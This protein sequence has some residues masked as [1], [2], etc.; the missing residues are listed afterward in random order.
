MVSHQLSGAAVPLMKHMRHAS[1]YADIPCYSHRNE[2]NREKR[3]KR[4]KNN[5]NECAEKKTEIFATTTHSHSCSSSTNLFASFIQRYMCW[6]VLLHVTNKH[7][8]A[9]DKRFAQKR[10]ASVEVH[11]LLLSCDLKAS[12][13]VM[14]GSYRTTKTNRNVWKYAGEK[15][16][17]SLSGAQGGDEWFLSILLCSWLSLAIAVFFHFCHLEENSKILNLNVVGN[18]RYMVTVFGNIFY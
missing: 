2:K 6:F 13:C 3:H 7:H 5:E 1:W 15:M 12:L 18:A 17:D 14:F 9:F 4:K 8:T 11:A 16:Y 10:P